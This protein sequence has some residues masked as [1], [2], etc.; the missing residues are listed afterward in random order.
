M[1][2]TVFSAF[3]TQI[4]ADLI[5]KAG[6]Y[7]GKTA[8]N[9]M[10]GAA[11]IKN[12][13]LISTGFHVQCG[14]PHAEVHALRAAGSRATGATLLITLEPCTHHGRTPPCTDAIIAAGIRRVIFAASDPNPN[15][16]HASDIL[17]PHGIS[18]SSGLLAAES[19][20]LNTVFHFAMTHKRPYVT[21][22]MAMDA[23]GHT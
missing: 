19:E 6:D 13:E 8:P 14:G 15:V 11:V 21:L 16:Q 3:E 20:A 17:E 23:A 5:H 4:M 2:T 7:N 12:T 10:V 9:P 22:K 18:V 1:T